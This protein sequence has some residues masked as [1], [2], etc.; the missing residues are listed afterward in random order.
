MIITKSISRFGRNTVDVLSVLHA[1]Q[2]QGIDVFFEVETL[3][4]NDP[5]NAFIISGIEALAQAESESHGEN[6]RISIHISLKNPDAKLYNRSC[7]GY[8]TDSA[9]RLMVVP[10]QAAIVQKIFKMYLNGHSLVSIIDDLYCSYIPSPAGKDKWSKGT[11]DNIIKNE[12]YIGDVLVVK[13]Y[14]EPYS[15][16]KRKTNR[17]DQMQCQVSNHHDPIITREIFQGVQ[18]ERA[19]RTNVSYEDGRPKRKNVKFSSKMALATKK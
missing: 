10:E 15:L 3:H 19:R 11:V 13:T 7:Y 18:E 1:L 8:Q 5:A 14:I 16:G 4:P 2:E 12:K 9:G 6:I 17:G